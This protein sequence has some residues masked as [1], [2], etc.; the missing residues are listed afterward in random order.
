MRSAWIAFAALAAC[1]SPPPRRSIDA[2]AGRAPVVDVP[3]AASV[4]LPWVPQLWPDLG[5]G[6]AT[7]ASVP[8]AR[9]RWS[10]GGTVAQDA[11][12]GT[13]ERFGWR[14]RTGPG[15]SLDGFRADH[16]GWDFAGERRVEICGRQARLVRATRAAQD[17]VCVMTATGNHPAWIP[18]QRAV[19]IQLVHREL[20]VVITFEVESAHAEAWDRAEAEFLASVRCF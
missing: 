13:D 8:V 10:P 9:A 4:E 19:A 18:P 2:P 5:L 7:F 12:R 1:P 16:Q 11:T 6:V 15:E 17:L 14:I 3:P 20:P